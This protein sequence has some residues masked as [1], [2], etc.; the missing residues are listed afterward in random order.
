MST[1]V[2]PPLTEALEDLL[3]GTC[4]GCGSL[5]EHGYQ[6]KSYWDGEV[7]TCTWQPAPY[8]HGG[9]NFL[10][11][12]II[13]SVLDC[14]L[15]MAG[16]LGLYASAGRV[17]G[18]DKGPQLFAVTANLNIDYLKPAPVEEAVTLTA[19]LDSVEGRK[20]RTSGTLGIGDEIMAKA[21]GLF[22]QVNR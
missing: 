19:T 9:A 15:C 13:A 1:L 4:Y 17:F 18:D 20:I 14:H 16:I 21:T 3:P 2:H 7:C 5:N 8:H 10:Y 11:G 6:I 22:I 12:G